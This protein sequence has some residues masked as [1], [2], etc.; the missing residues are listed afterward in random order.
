MDL[1]SL[2]AMWD[3]FADV[4][5]SHSAPGADGTIIDL[6]RIGDQIGGAVKVNFHDGITD[7]EGAI[8]GSPTNPTGFTNGCATRMS[9][10]LNH[11]GVAIPAIRGETVTGADGKNYIYRVRAINAYLHGIFG[12]PDI[13][14]GSDAVAEDFANQQGILVFSISFSDASGHITL[15]DGQEAVDEEYFSAVARHGAPLLGASLWLC[16]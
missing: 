13:S 2:N 7:I 9:Y 12:N 15:W 4:A 1:P 5:P 3:R 14:M 6:R 10:V 8:D 11:N 16:P